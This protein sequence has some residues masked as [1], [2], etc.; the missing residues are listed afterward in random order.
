MMNG[1]R[2]LMQG[3]L[4]LCFCA[5]GAWASTEGAIS[6]QV[7]DPDGIAVSNVKVKLLSPEGKNLGEATS[8]ATGE[9]YFSPL[10]FGE[11]EVSVQ[12]ANFAPS[13]SSV[14]VGSGGAAQVEVHLE[15]AAAPGK[16]MV[17][18]VSAKRHLINTSS[19]TSNTEV[20]H[21][22]IEAL[23]GGNEISL[24]RLLE[25]T[26]PGVVQGPFNQTFI[27]G[28]HANVQYQIDGV[29]L[30]DSTSGT[31]AEAFSTRNIDH[32]EF[33]SGGIPAE[34]GERLA[35]VVNI[36]TKTGPEKPGG[37][38]Q[39]NYGTYNTFSP[40]AILGGS[41]EKGDLH[42][43]LSANYNRT[44]RG[45]DVPNPKSVTD[46]SQGG[47]PSHDYSDGNNQFLKVDWLPT[48]EDKI[49]FIAF[50]NY[51]FY[52]IPTYPSSFSPSSPYFGVNYNDAFGN[53]P[54]A[55]Q[56]LFVYT[57]ADTNDTQANQDA[58]GQVVWKHTIS[59]R[60]FLQVAPYWKY[61]KVKVTNDPDN[62]LI[63]AN[64]ASPDYIAG[65]TPSSFSIDRHVNNVGEKTDYSNRLND[66]NLFKAGFQ[67]QASQANDGYSVLNPTNS[68]QPSFS[69]GDIDRGYSEDLYAQDDLQ[70]T[71]IL[72][73]NFGLRFTATQ[74][75]FSDAHPTADQWQPRIGANLMVTDR[76]K[77]HAFY[78]RLFQPAP[79]EDLREAFNY[80]NAGSGTT[81]SFYDIK[82]ETDNYYEIGVDQQLGQNQLATLN[83]YYKD[84]TNMLD[85]T[86]LLNTSIASPYNFEKGYAYGAEASIKGK[87]TPNLTNYI[88]Y[89]YEIAKGKGISGG[90]FAVPL[91]SIPQ[92]TYLYLDHVQVSTANAGLTYA[93]D[94]YY[95]TV[96]GLFGSGLRTGPN[97]TL[98][99]PTHFSFD[100][101]AGYEFTSDRWLERWKVSGD[102][103]NLFDNAYP[104][105]IANG[106]NGSHYAAGREL[107]IRL[108]KEL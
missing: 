67:L 46:Q 76:T 105:S 29:Q 97:N 90:T 88:N 77:L 95:G 48:N 38:V 102:I 57:P 59:D 19:S 7:L 108:T 47:D 12:A 83:F 62:D 60:S 73:F 37:E 26:T 56:T 15:P 9:F 71:R 45:I 106:F 70:L 44:D 107:F 8:S 39:L 31:F 10:T 40:Q 58:Y 68:T 92:D 21:E 103:I 51:G 85:D 4:L 3:S 94:R 65:A 6:G 81:V 89:S 96:Q 104:I 99:L 13:M 50:Q 80:A 79:L 64:S 66:R 43:Y 11:Y 54:P 23:P 75:I 55:G 42:Y 93:K 63:S 34:Y 22:Q 53:V 32:F 101:S 74:F 27:R 100:L 72:S 1:F 30:P 87:I 86:Q 18:Q 2:K 24:P 41:N 33:I 14:N 25:T 35:A 28:N 78:G 52:Q 17:L 20:T 5:S 84:A 61:S 69:G 49:S 36:V 98:S 91:N 82:P 16:E